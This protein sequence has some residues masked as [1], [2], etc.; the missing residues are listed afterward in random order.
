MVKCKYEIETSTPLG[1]DE[2]AEVDG[3]Y[4]TAWVLK[5]D[6]MLYKL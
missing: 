3:M 5:K 4:F 1:P 2:T 6:S